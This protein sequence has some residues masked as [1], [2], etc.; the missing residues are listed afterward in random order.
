MSVPKLGLQEHF[1]SRELPFKV[2]PVIM[3]KVKKAMLRF[4]VTHDHISTSVIREGSYYF[5]NDLKFP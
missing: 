5:F 3:T 1:P 4:Y 2:D